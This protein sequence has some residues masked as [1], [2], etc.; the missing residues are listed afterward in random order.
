MKM[1]MIKDLLDK[2]KK[3]LD[4]EREKVKQLSAVELELKKANQDIE[5]LREKVQ[6]GETE[7]ETL[8]AKF[9]KERA[10]GKTID[11]QMNGEI[12]GMNDELESTKKQETKLQKEVARLM[13]QMQDEQELN[14]QEIKEKDEEIETLKNRIKDIIS[15]G[16]Q[17]LGQQIEEITQELE[18]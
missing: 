15:K 1:N 14:D 18:D 3:D 9:D 10:K 2:A 7:I 11:Q 12:E 4:E 16:N 6:D 8:K 5:L 13:K 17:G